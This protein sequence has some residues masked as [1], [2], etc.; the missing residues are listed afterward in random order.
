MR[1][2]F[3]IFCLLAANTIFAQEKRPITD[4]EIRNDLANQGNCVV[5]IHPRSDLRVYLYVDGQD[6]PI[7]CSNY[8]PEKRK[9]DD[10]FDYPYCEGLKFSEGAG[11]TTA[12]GR[13]VT[14]YSTEVYQPRVFR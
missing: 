7:H 6:E 2:L 13:K 4:L 12:D 10:R 9:E 11:V 5:M 3:V 8:S 1:K 14:H